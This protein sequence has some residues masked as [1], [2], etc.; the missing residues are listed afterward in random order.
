MTVAATRE[1]LEK[2]LA[3]LKRRAELGM[4]APTNREIALRALGMGKQHFQPWDRT[5]G[6]RSKKPE[7]GAVMIRQLEAAGLILVERGRNWRRIVL[8]ETGQVL[9]P[10]RPQ[11]A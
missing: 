10:Q 5:Q 1:R 2:T 6:I 4:P 7:H 8:V 11:F 9:E 3:Y